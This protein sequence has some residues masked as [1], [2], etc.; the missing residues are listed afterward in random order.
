MAT[1]TIMCSCGDVASVHAD[2]HKEAVEIL[3]QRW[4]AGALRAHL[5]EK[6]PDEHIPT[7]AELFQMIAGKLMP[8]TA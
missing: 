3:A 6:H 4:S 8:M 7:H 5:R 2:T 1:F